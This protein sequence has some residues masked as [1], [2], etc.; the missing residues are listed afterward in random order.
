[1]QRHDDPALRQRTAHDMWKLRAEQQQVVNVDDVRPEV[2]Q[3][4]RQ[5]G[6]D[7]VEI[8]L[9]HE[10]PVEVARPQ[11]QFVSCRSDPLKAGARACLSVDLVGGAQE[12]RFAARTLIG[13]EQVVGENFRASR[14]KGRMVVSRDEDAHAHGPLPRRSATKMS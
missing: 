4:F 5:V 3:Q 13:A 7:A 10:K 1:M 6:N 8:D 9:A 11:Q 2:A 14:V 12:E